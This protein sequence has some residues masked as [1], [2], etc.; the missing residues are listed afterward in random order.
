[1]SLSFANSSVP[2]RYNKPVAKLFMFKKK[3]ISEIFCHGT[4]DSAYVNNDMCYYHILL[5]DDNSKI[6]TCFWCLMG[7]GWW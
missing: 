6:F 4:L 2:Y 1:M 7:E 3:P 5:R